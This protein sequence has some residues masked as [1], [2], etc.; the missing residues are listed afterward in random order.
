LVIIAAGGAMD[1]QT[2][3]AR[4]NEIL[5]REDWPAAVTAI[6]EA[7]G[8]ELLRYLRGV[9]RDEEQARDVFSEASER[10]WTSLPA[11][12][13]EASVRTWAYRLAW[14]AAADHRRRTARRREARLPTEEISKI[15]QEVCERTPPFLKTD[16]KAKLA[17]IRASLEPEERSLLLLRVESELSWRDVADVMSAG[18]ARVDAAT[19]RKRFERLRRKLHDLAKRNG[20]RP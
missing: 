11:F 9:L 1:E 15:V 5:D 19:L 12:R 20:L 7:F 17:E 8:P 13:R 18:G 2:V 14:C 10:L 4:I 6:L 3:E 16:A